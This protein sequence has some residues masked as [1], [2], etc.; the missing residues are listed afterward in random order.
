MT[1]WPLRVAALLA[2]A[3]GLP[4]HAAGPT[5]AVR[6]GGAWRVWWRADQA[7]ARWPGPDPRLT[8]ALAWR[9]LADGVRWSTARI[10]GSAPAWRTRLVVV[11]ID[12][13]RVRLSLELALSPGDGR[14]AWTIDRA[15]RGALLA[16]NA[17]QFVQTMPWGW[18]V[19][20]GRERLRPCGGPLSVAVAVEASGAVR[21]MAADSL[22]GATGIVTAFQSYPT[23]L[24]DDGRI[25]L[26]LREPG[27]GVDLAHRDA[28]L[29]IGETRDGELLIVMT[30]FDALGAGAGRVPIGPTTPEMAA[31]MGAL[32]AR[33]AV[34]LD[35]GISAQMTLRDRG[36]AVRARWPGLRKVPLA[37]LVW[38]RE[39]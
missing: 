33:D 9:T 39:P 24:A 23:L 38:P 8:G 7:A 25:P 22:A 11:R 5:L 17:G 14:P 15:P 16:V 12:P 2:L 35:G 27:Q 34:M 21:W 10:A 29:A 3:I 32:G 13:R 36:G 30:R 6:D 31:I 19:M 26:A 37:L 18:L 20:Q 28:R 1:R 4:A